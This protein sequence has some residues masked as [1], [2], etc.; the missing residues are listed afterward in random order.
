MPGILGVLFITAL[1]FLILGMI[2]PKLII[3]WGDP[4]RRTRKKALVGYGGISLLLLVLFIIISP[5]PRKD[6]IADTTKQTTSNHLTNNNGVITSNNPSRESTSDN[7]VASDV[8]FEQEGYAGYITGTVKNNTN[9]AYRY[10]EV[11]INVYDESGAQIASPMANTQNLQAG[12][13]WRF[14]APIIPRPQSK[15]SYKVI[16]VV[17]R[18]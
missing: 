14:K 18:T 13:T 11:N 5:A 10:V 4:E 2:W 7:L 17:G 9:H 1:L 16:K 3:L 8:G 12:G 15:F 6:I